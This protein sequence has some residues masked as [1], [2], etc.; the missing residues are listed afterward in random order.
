[1]MDDISKNGIVDTQAEVQ[2][3]PLPEIEAEAKG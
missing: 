3:R 2:A 1:M